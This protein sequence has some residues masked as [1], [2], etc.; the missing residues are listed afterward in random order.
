MLSFKKKTQI[1]ILAYYV[2]T[3][4]LPCF[5]DRLLTL[6]SFTCASLEQTLICPA[7]ESRVGVIL[8]KKLKGGAYG[9]NH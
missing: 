2:K 6:E 7:G 3:R 5:A 8:Q 9:G 1:N 4:L